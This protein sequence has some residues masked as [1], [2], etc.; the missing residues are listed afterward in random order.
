MNFIQIIYKYSIPVLQE[1]RYVTIS[2]IYRRILFTDRKKMYFYSQNLVKHINRVLD[3][4]QR[5]FILNQV[6]CKAAP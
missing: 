5:I 1:G 4:M 2:K 3:K 6:A